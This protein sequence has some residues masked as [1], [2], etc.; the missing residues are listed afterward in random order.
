MYC[1]LVD[2]QYSPTLHQRIE[3]SKLGSQTTLFSKQLFKYTSL[4]NLSQ[5]LFCLLLHIHAFSKI[6]SSFPFLSLP[7]GSFLLIDCYVKLL[8]M[9]LFTNSFPSR[10]SNYIQ[11]HIDSFIAI[12][13]AMGL[14]PFPSFI[15]LMS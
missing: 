15:L 2:Y 8:K 13:M 14:M 7:F 4:F 9:C 6:S 1:I 5:I 11:S 10:L 12:T 3:N